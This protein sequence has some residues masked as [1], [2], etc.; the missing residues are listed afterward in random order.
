[1]ATFKRSLRSGRDVDVGRNFGVRKVCDCT[2]RIK[3]KCDH[4]WHFNFAWNGKSY[5]FS[6]DRQA[7][8]H[9]ELRADAEAL[10]DQ[11]RIAIRAG[12]FGKPPK[13]SP[14]PEGAPLT[15][16][17]FAKE[18]ASRR[19]YQLVRSRDNDYR[20][21]AIQAFAL[22]GLDPPITFGEKAVVSITTGDIEAYRHHRRARGLSA[23][24]SNHDLKLLRKMFA[25]GVRE[26]LIPSTPFKV[27]TETVIKLDPE[28][29]RERR[30]KSDDDEEALLLAAN[31]HLRAVIIAMLDT[32]CRPGELLSLQ[33]RDVDLE[34]RQLVVRPE[35]TKTRRGRL[36]PI[37]SRLLS[38]LQMRRLGPDG[39][40]LP[41]EAYVFGDAVGN[42]TTSIRTAWENARE[43]AGLGDFHLA[44]LRHEAAS[45][46]E[47]AGVPTTY[48][49]KFLGHRN[50]TTTTRYLNT[51]VRGLRLAI[52][53]LEAEQKKPRPLADGLQ[54]DAPPP[55]DTPVSSGR[56]QSSKSLI[57]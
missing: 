34:R 13:P 3:A 32:C 27:V 20:L 46:F 23:V 56:R 50:L 41:Q 1:M 16:A 54:T 22:P 15:F 53:K 6:L 10:A 28:T 51:T 2:R 36:L 35:K 29:P 47:E 19:G 33:W 43:A 48:V 40:E 5:R 42:R 17:E 30:F 14:T 8:R 52:E 11:I 25:W 31:P 45:R 38:T 39:Q 18:W 7:G 44:D 26:R 21:K 4:P 37:S 49:S 12:E 55:S 57:S 9:I 24:T